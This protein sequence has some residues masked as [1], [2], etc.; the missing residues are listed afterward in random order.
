MST[1]RS[2]EERFYSAPDGLRLFARIYRPKKEEEEAG[3]HVVCLS[4]LTRNSRDFHDLAVHLSS[5]PDRPRTVVAFD[6]RGRGK[7]QYD[8]DWRNYNVQV[9]AGDIL[10]GL[11]AF[12]IGQADFIAT[13]RGGLVLFV[14]AARRPGAIR[15]AVLNDIGPVMEGEGLAQL[16]AYLERAPHPATLADAVQLQKA[17][18][19]GAFPALSDEDWE[20]M[21][22]ATHRFEQDQPVA[23]FDPDLLRTI[24]GIDFNQPLPVFWPQ[25]IGLTPMPVLAIRGEHSNLLSE[26][27]LAAMRANHPVLETVTVSGQGHAPMLETAGL[28]DRIADF[29]SRAGKTG[30]S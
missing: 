4:G 29:L 21:V 1:D 8:P 28:P 15:S 2:H 9:E 14:L 11:T 22:K 19:G 27:T 25:F 3:S 5:L 26:A 13:S 30:R 23:D 12:G 7:S 16:R 17:A 20:R 6:Y 18:H 24:A 10:A